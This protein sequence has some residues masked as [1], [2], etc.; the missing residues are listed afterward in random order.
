MLHE[1]AR[2]VGRRRGALPV[3][4]L[5]G[6]AP[7]LNALATREQAPTEHHPR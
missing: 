5:D 6:H 3:R 4:D 2:T 7:N 1:P